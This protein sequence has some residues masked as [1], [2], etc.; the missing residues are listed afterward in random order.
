M[1]KKHLLEKINRKL[2][3]RVLK[4]YLLLINKEKNSI[5]RA[6]KK[7][8]NFAKRKG[9]KSNLIDRLI[10]D[11]KKLEDIRKSLAKIIKLKD[12]VDNVL[13]KWVRPNGL[14]ISKVT[15]PL[16]L[17][18]LF[19]KVGPMLPQMLPVYVLNLVML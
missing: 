9:L 12:P 6:N 13:E 11:E 14:H 8:V 18:V 4:R 5:L 17:L 19:M 1:Q 2:K 15:I 3:N 10:L 16:G 7:D